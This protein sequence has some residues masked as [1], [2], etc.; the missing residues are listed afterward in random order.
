MILILNGL[1]VFIHPRSMIPDGLFAKP[2]KI[3][4]YGVLSPVSALLLVRLTEKTF[5]RKKD[6]RIEV[7]RNPLR[8]SS[9]PPRPLFEGDSTNYEQV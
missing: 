3:R 7:C 8:H 5:S 1:V 6:G 2:S 4:A 9:E